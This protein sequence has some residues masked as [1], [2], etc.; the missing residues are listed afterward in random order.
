MG[1]NAPVGGASANATLE[2]Y[3]QNKKLLVAKSKSIRV[4]QG[5]TR[6]RQGDG[7]QIDVQDNT[8]LPKRKKKEPQG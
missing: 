8:S 4:M 1:D 5:N 7:K 6:G 3:A 2:Q